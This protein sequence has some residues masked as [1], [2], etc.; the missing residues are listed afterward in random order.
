M[1]KDDFE[2]VPSHFFEKG[3]YEVWAAKNYERNAPIVM[4]ASGVC[5]ET[6]KAFNWR[7]KEIRLNGEIIDA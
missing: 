6:A 2:P 1:N 3:P 5:L 4:I 7:R